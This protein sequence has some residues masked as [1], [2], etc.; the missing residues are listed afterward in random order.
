MKLYNLANIEFQHI[1]KSKENTKP[2]VLL[3]LINLFNKYGYYMGGA[4]IGAILIDRGFL[5]VQFLKVLYPR[6]YYYYV[7]KYSL[8]YHIPVNLIY[9][10]IRQESMFDPV[11]YSSA[12]AIGLMQIIPPTGYYIAGKVGCRYFNP[13]FLYRSN[14]NIQFGSYYLSSL[15]NE[16]NGEKYLAVASYNAGPNAVSYWK[17]YT[18]R[19]SKR[20]LFIESIPYNQTR[21]YVKMVLRNYYIYKALY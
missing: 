6:P 14:L 18:L 2:A 21:N 19:E 20:L 10:I 11:C 12:G 1:L 13:A 15:L 9:A 3:G 7:K 16:F 17:N 5:T 8:R 4:E